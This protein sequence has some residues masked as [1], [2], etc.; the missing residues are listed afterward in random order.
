MKPIDL[1][2]L[3]IAYGKELQPVQLQKILFLLGAKTPEHAL[4]KQACYTFS[5]YD[6]GPF[7]ADVYFDAEKLEQQGLIRIRRPPASR[8]KEYSIT[9]NGSQA[10]VDIANRLHPEVSSYL[11][12][13]VNYTKSLSFNELVSAVYKAFPEMKVNSVFKETK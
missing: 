7:C 5:P 6:Y 3:T 13:L 8:Y 11:K 12:T 10:S 1:N 9:E 4:E 2:L